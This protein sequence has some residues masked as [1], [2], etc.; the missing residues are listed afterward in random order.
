MYADSQRCGGKLASGN[1][2]GAFAPRPRRDR[3]GR[4]HTRRSVE[5]NHLGAIS[6]GVDDGLIRTGVCSQLACVSDTIEVVVGLRRIIDSRTIV[7]TVVDAISVRIDRGITHRRVASH[8][9]SAF[10]HSA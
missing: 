8:V 3:V 9:R 6:A 1:Q 4:R 5:L 7:I 2:G 10:I